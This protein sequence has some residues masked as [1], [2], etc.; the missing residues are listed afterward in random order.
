MWI[1]FDISYT[2]L[3]YSV[4]LSNFS[5]GWSILCVFVHIRYTFG[6]SMVPVT[7]DFIPPWWRRCLIWRRDCE[8][9]KPTIWGFPWV[10]TN[11]DTQKCM[12]YHGQS[13]LEMDE[14]WG[15]SIWVYLGVD[16]DVAWDIS[17]INGVVC[18][19][20]GIGLGFKA[21]FSWTYTDGSI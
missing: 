17:N 4:T 12:I 6:W 19:T 8:F 5:F 10:S 16:W 7:C 3:H 21:P 18:K 9:V 13:H 14:N 1:L 20:S 11:G 2:I 15:Y